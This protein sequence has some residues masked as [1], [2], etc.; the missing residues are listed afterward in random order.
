MHSELHFLESLL[1]TGKISRRQFIRQTASLGLTAA[2]TPSLL[3]GTAQ[4]ATPKRGGHFRLGIAHGDTTDSLDPATYTDDG[5]V[6]INW[7]LRNNLVE[8]DHKGDPIPELAES[9]EH[10]SDVK[11][12][13]FNIRK[14]V[15]FHNGKTMDSND[16]VESLQHHLNKNSK[17][18]AKSILKP[19]KEIKADG[20]YKVIIELDGGSADFLFILCDYR[21]TIQPAKTK[22]FGDGIGTGGYTLQSYQPGA[23][24]VLKRFSNYWKEGRAH[25]DEVDIISIHDL[26]AR[27]NALRSKEVDAINACDYKTIDLFGNLPGIQSIISTGTRHY[28]YPMLCNTVPF[29]NNDVRLALKYAIDREKILRAVFRGYGKVG[30]DHP[31]GP[32]QRFFA[33]DLELRSYDPDKA[34]Y[35]MKK[36]G[37]EGHKF[38]LVTSQSV[39]DVSVDSALLY[40]EHAKMAGINI[41][42][43]KAPADGYWNDIWMKKPWA[44]SRWAGRAT[45]DWM[46][47]TAYASGASWNEARWEN[48][49]FNKILIEARAELDTAKRREMYYELQKIVRDDGGS[50][51]FIFPSDLHAANDKVKFTN[52]AGNYQMDGLKCCERWW[53]EG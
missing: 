16:V 36:A 51:V 52:L 34:R 25:F 49:R 15:E 50:I 13:V 2:I 23:K 38:T 1:K 30:N 11:T 24:T 26:S 21:L 14:G 31:I 44:S 29:D 4:A 40:K 22:D 41:D 18:A 27:T 35:Y 48:E 3:Y 10:S 33:K 37:F 20:K 32:S 12:W 7:C 45:E 6:V 46:F 47:S 17:S 19:I 39:G 8:I 28:T 5:D 9:W 53:F 43:Q 42:I